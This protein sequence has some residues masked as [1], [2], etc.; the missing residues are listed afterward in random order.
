MTTEYMLINNTSKEVADE[1]FLWQGISQDDI[2]QRTTR[3]VAYVCTLRDSGKL[4]HSITP[5][6]SKL[7]NLD[8]P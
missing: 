8:G 3:F 1:L 4:S 6:I 2:D 7:S 5:T